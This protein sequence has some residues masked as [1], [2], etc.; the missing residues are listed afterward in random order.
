VENP[1]RDAHRFFK[2]KKMV[3]PVPIS[4]LTIP[5]VEADDKVLT[6]PYIKIEDYFTCSEAPQVVDWGS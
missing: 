4:T 2:R 6:V 5:A 1:E 3:L